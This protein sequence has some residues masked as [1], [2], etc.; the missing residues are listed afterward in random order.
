MGHA[1]HKNVYW[2]RIENIHMSNYYVRAQSFG[3]SG[4]GFLYKYISAER[5]FQFYQA[6]YK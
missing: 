3:E 2:I 6:L 4:P 1:W 5:Q